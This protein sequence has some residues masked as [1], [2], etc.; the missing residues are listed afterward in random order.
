MNDEERNSE[1]TKSSSGLLDTITGKIG[2]LK[3]LLLVLGGFGSNA[4]NLSG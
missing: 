2:K 4:G 3:A 1:S